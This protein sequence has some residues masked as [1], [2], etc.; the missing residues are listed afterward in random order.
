MKSSQF[1]EKLDGMDIC[2]G[3]NREMDERSLALFLRIVGSDEMLATLI[4]RLDEGDIGATVD[5]FTGLMK[6]HLSE[7]EYHRLF[8]GEE[9]P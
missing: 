7:S 1:S 2:F 6:K 8:L 3:L 4:P 5:F 9:H